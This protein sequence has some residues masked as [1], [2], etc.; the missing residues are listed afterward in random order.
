M[1][2][3]NFL[4]ASIYSPSARFLTVASFG[5][6]SLLVSYSMFAKP[7]TIP[8]IW[9]GFKLFKV[10]LVKIFIIGICSY[11]FNCLITSGD[12]LN[13]EAILFKVS[14]LVVIYVSYILSLPI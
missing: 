11:P 9:I 4:K 7:P 13:L 5:G 2:S 12:V 6:K 10:L 8:A 3:G 1:P 14:P